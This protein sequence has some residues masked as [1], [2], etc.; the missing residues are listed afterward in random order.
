MVVMM[1]SVSGVAAALAADSVAAGH[2]SAAAGWYE[3]PAA[4]HQHLASQSGSSAATDAEIA[5]A[6][7]KNQS[8]LGAAYSMSQQGKTSY[9]GI[10][11]EGKETDILSFD[12]NFLARDSHMMSAAAGATGHG[13][14]SGFHPTNFWGNSLGSTPI[15]PG[16]FSS[17]Q[18]QQQYPSASSGSL[19]G[20]PSAKDIKSEHYHQSHHQQQ[21]HQHLDHS[22]QQQQVY[23]HSTTPVESGG[24]SPVSSNQD[25]KSPSA[26]DSYSTSSTTSVAPGMLKPRPEGS[27]SSYATSNPSPNPP[28]PHQTTASVGSVS[29]PTSTA[30]PYFPSPASEIYGTSYS[31]TGNTFT[32]SLQQQHHQQQQ[33]CQSSSKSRSKAK[34]NA[35][36]S[37]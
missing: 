36:K 34:S 30:Y 20:Y 16:S 18:K 12:I 33:H 9:N 35:G 5:D 6:Y 14:Y 4:A 7:F 21:Q 11:F 27:A 23:Q 17:Y 8:Y 25:L 1:D 22:Q 15:S 3:S 24:I 13:L 10:Q 2:R 28:S 29:S 37:A 26:V 19:I 31:T 32:K